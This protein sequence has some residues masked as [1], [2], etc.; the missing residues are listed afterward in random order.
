MAVLATEGWRGLFR[1]ITPNMLK[2]SEYRRPQAGYPR[3]A[4]RASQDHTPRPMWSHP[5]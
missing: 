3:L 5:A 2:A 4:C 1:G